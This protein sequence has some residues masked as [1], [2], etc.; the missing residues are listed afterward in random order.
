MA[1]RINLLAEEQAAEELRRKNPVKLVIWVGSFLVIAMALWIV[2]LQLDIGY[3]KTKYSSLD[4]QWKDNIAKYAAVTN[5]MAKIA[6]IDKKLDAL[7]RLSTNRFF[8]GPVLDAFQQTVVNDI[9]VTR[10]AGEQRY[11]KEEAK[12]IGTGATKK[13]IPGSTVEK[14]TLYVDAKDYNPNAQTYDKFKETLS[15][16]G[17]FVSNLQRGFVLEGTLSAPS[18]D[19][20]DLNKQFVNFKLVAHF[21]DMTHQ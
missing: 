14:T 15:D 7:D 10:L 5:N 12:T 18:V 16:F 13:V 19:P 9:Q 6:E 17:F 3:S 11:V 2:K 4:Q 1:I 20:T 21:K 8:W